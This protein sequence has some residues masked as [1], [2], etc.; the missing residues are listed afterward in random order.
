MGRL[1]ALRDLFALVLALLVAAVGTAVAAPAG[2][3]EQTFFTR[4][5][6]CQDDARLSIQ[7]GEGD[8]GCG[9]AETGLNEVKTIMGHPVQYIEFPTADG[10]PVVLDTSRGGSGQ[11]TVANY[12]S[13]DGMAVGRAWVDVELIGTGK[14]PDGRDFFGTVAAAR[15]EEYLRLVR[16]G[17]HT[18]S[19]ALDIPES[20]QDVTFESLTLRVTVNG[21]HGG[22]GGVVSDGHSFVT[23]PVIPAAE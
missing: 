5:T 18:S 23:L 8:G 6:W 11:I 14:Q 16:G 17:W 12:A 2:D 13:T 1:R 9:F 15:G 4:R 3:E 7:H 22:H 10:V 19:F 20:V 21:T